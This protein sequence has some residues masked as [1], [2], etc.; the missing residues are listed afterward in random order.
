MDIYVV[1]QPAACSEL[2]KSYQKRFSNFPA[3][4]R[5]YFLLQF[6]DICKHVLFVEDEIRVSLLA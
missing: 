2:S 4:S 1:S 6:C 3:V 5:F